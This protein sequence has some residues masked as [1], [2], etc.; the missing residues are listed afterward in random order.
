MHCSS[1]RPVH[2]FL[3]GLRTTSKIYECMCH[4]IDICWQ[5]AATA[6]LGEIHLRLSH[7]GQMKLTDVKRLASPIRFSL[8]WWCVEEESSAGEA[9]PGAER[10]SE[11][12]HEN[13]RALSVHTR[14]LKRLRGA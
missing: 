6:Y 10:V 1:L 7:Q 8:F 2:C 12:V 3:W 14:V 13:L 4:S 11:R 5:V 9:P